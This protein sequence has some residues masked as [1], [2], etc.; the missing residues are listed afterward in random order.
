MRKAV[1][2]NGIVTNVIEAGPDFE[3][4]G[5]TLVDA[6]NAG[7][8]WTWDGETFTPPEPEPEPIPEVV[9]MRQARL[10][11]LGAG[12]LSQVDGAIDQM[13]EPQQSEA[14][15]E[16]EY[17]TELRRHHPLIVALGAALEL[18]DEAIDALFVQAAGIE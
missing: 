11:L 6:G 1:I 5:K 8:G 14:R 10:A 3:L 17:A 12:L 4:P 13:D 16:W 7:I 15:I 2:E 9:S 18:D